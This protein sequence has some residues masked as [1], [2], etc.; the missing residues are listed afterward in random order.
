VRPRSDSSSYKRTD[1]Y[2]GISDDNCDFTPSWLYVIS[3]ELTPS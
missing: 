2:T 1:V 3:P